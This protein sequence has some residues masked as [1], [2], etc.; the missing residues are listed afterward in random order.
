MKILHVITG[1][2]TGGAEA[3]LYKL[4]RH[5]TQQRIQHAVC[6]L[7]G[8]GSFGPKIAAL[9]VPVHDLD[10]TMIGI[11][12]GVRSLIARLQPNAVQGWMYHGNLAASLC[13]PSAN[14]TAVLW[15]IRQTLSPFRK[16]KPGTA[17]AIR[18]GAFLSRHPS[19]IIYNS[20][21][22]ALQH[23]A[24]GYSKAKTRII[25]NGFDTDLLKPDAD[26][27]RA[28]RR[29]INVSDETALIGAVG[30]AHPMKDHTNFLLAA[31]K[32]KAVSSK[33]MFLLA[34]RETDSTD[35]HSRVNQLGLDGHVRLLGERDD[36]PAV[37]A[38]LDIFVLSSA[39]GEAFPNVVGEAMACGLPC[40]VTDVGDAREIVADT[41]IVVPPRD[42][43]AMA[44]AVVQLLASPNRAQLGTRARERIIGLYS[45]G[46][47]TELYASL[48]RELIDR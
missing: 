33:A 9:G 3:S 12:G 21:A 19:C 11:V 35:M 38:A 34:G 10:G 37:M 23:E 25:P 36:I 13:R 16:E 29:M 26:A 40:I 1:L 27:R 6:S 39:W 31:Q 7:K 4:L 43:D 45:V 8:R 47:M 30:R 20:Q 28:F 17:F 18:L 24:V 41:G 46:T 15:N 44:Y 48:Y 14:R 5:P 42:L 32:I 22:A 2:E